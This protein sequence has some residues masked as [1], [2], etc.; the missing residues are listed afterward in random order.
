MVAL[1]SLLAGLGA[2]AAAIVAAYALRSQ[3]RAQQR[4]HDLENLRWITAQWDALRGLRRRAAED[5]LDGGVDEE[6]LRDVLNFFESCG[7]LVREEFITAKTFDQIA[8]LAVFGWWYGAETFIRD[9][10]VRL[11]DDGV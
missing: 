11:H 6:A 8:K 3:Q 7:Y 9:V 5:Y 4:Q 2:A 10:R 1:A